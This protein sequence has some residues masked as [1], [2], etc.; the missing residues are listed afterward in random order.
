MH[1]SLF[2]NL[3][4][5]FLPS[6]TT[7]NVPSAG[8]TVLIPTNATTPK[9]SCCYIRQMILPRLFSFCRFSGSFRCTRK[10]RTTTTVA[11]TTTTTTPRTEIFSRY[12]PPLYGRQDN[13]DYGKPCIPGFER[14]SLG[15]CVG[16]PSTHVTRVFPNKSNC[17]PH[18]RCLLGIFHSSIAL[19]T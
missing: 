2:L 9:A 10:V 12:T 13:R 19:A 17:F 18:L 11:T 7:M 6:Q 1:K 4:C 16:K 14:N 3:V 5:H 15:A 8:T